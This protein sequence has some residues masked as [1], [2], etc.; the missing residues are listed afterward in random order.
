MA[1]KNKS[2]VPLNQMS[3]K[4]KIIH[5]FKIFGISFAAVIGL[6]AGITLY[7]WATGGF[8]PP[9]EPLTAWAFSQSE[10]VIDGNKDI[11]IDS[12]GNQKYDN[13]KLLFVQKTNNNGDALYESIMIV[14]NEG[15]TELD[16]EIKISFSSNPNMPVVQLVEDENTKALD[17]TENDSEE[18]LHFKYSVKIGSPIYI[19]P[20][21]TKIN[22]RDTNLGG[23]A[24]LTATQG[25]MQ[26]SCWVFVDVPVEKLTL[27]LD[28]SESFEASAENDEIADE[29]YYNVFT[30]SSLHISNTIT[31]NSATNLPKSNVPTSKV[32]NGIAGATG[33]LNEKKVKK[34]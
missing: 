10:Y 28:N 25:L 11:D 7:V 19:K 13:G 21:T 15:C 24:M 2:F 33:F 1:K 3:R 9:Y 22:D 34:K 29:V 5:F 17:A 4:D 23:W 31:P 26:T 20:V 16:A 18:K 30:N 12:D 6:F 27:S 8:N 32:Y 14:P